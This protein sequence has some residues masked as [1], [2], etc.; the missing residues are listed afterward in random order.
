[1]LDHLAELE[2]GSFKT[3][4]KFVHVLV[5][6]A[7]VSISRGLAFLAGFGRIRHPDDRQRRRRRGDKIAENIDNSRNKPIRSM[8]RTNN[9]LG[10]RLS[11]LSMSALVEYSRRVRTRSWIFEALKTI[12]KAGAA[13]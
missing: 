10:K 11:D 7:G 3:E 4:T 2:Y 13:P 1:M 8:V 5:V 9:V 12:S 6:S